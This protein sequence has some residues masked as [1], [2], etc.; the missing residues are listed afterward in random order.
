MPLLP[1]TSRLVLAAVPL[2]Q[3]ARVL[4]QRDSSTCLMAL[5]RRLRRLRLRLVRHSPLRVSHPWTWMAMT[6]SEK[7][8]R[9]LCLVCNK[10]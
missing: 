10:D 6:T 8:S 3:L 1:R 5:L 2:L 9:P 7:C 4:L